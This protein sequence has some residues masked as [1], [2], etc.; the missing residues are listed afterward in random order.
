MAQRVTHD[1]ELNKIKQ[2]LQSGDNEDA[3]R[4]LVYPLFT[5]L[6]K[7]KF[8]VESAAENAD[9]YVDGKLI[10]ECK[11]AYADW[12]PGFYQALHYAK[13]GLTFSTVC[14]IAKEFLAVW[15][16]DKL[17]DEAVIYAHRMDA[18]LAAQKAGLENARRTAPSLKKE[19]L[20]ATLYKITPPDFQKPDFSPTYQLYA[21]L[22]LLNN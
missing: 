17:P 21:F 5:K 18:T 16:V 12:L 22:K 3:K 9:G 1:E 15:K 11:T 7:E 19:I 8:K 13:K 10:I 14:V 4:P 6:F 20:E 2:Y